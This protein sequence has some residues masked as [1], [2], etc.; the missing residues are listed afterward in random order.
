[1]RAHRLAVDLAHF[2]DGEGTLGDEHLPRFLKRLTLGY[3]QTTARS[4]S[5]CSTCF[6]VRSRRRLFGRDLPVAGISSFRR[7]GRRTRPCRGGPAR[8]K[9]GCSPWSRSP[10]FSV[11]ST[12]FHTVARVWSW[13]GSV[14]QVALSPTE[15]YAS[16]FPFLS[17]TR[18][19]RPPP[20]KRR[21]GPTWQAR[22]HFP[23]TNGS[24]ASASLAVVV[25]VPRCLQP[26]C[27]SAGL[28]ATESSSM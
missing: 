9:T 2:R 10:E 21:Q 12:G 26:V 11:P 1:M 5:Q 13:T 23:V 8:C 17:S 3:L 20:A 7:R 18:R 16:T 24:T 15:S 28:W 19:A 4:Q 6:S 25:P 27:S 14:S 22:L